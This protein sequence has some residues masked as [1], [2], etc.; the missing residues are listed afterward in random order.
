MK[1]YIL[2]KANAQYAIV[3]LNRNSVQITDDKSKATLLTQEQADKYIQRCTKK[4]KGFQK[5]EKQEEEKKEQKETDRKAAEQTKTQRRQLTN[6]EKL[7][8]YV[9]D[10]GR[11]GICGQFVPPNAYTIDHIVPISKGGTYDYSNL[12]CCCSACNRMKA[13]IMPDDLVDKMLEIME[14]QAEKG[15]KRVKKKMKAIVKKKK[16]KSR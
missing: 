11:C 3:D 14:Y 9:R 2:C 1:T 5:I 6:Q 12:Q 8:I 15:N 16:K 13:D 4:L 10:K 7:D